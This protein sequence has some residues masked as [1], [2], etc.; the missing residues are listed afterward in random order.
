MLLSK[1]K[2]RIKARKNL[3]KYLLQFFAII[4]FL[5]GS[6][7]AGSILWFE[8]LVFFAEI[9]LD[10]RQ[11]KYFVFDIHNVLIRASFFKRLNLYLVNYAS[12][13]NIPLY[14]VRITLQRVYPIMF[15]DFGRSEELVE[16]GKQ[17]KK[18]TLGEIQYSDFNRFLSGFFKKIKSSVSD[19]DE[20]MLLDEVFMFVSNTDHFA[21]Y[22][23]QMQYGFKIAERIHRKFGPKALYILADT[24]E[25]LLYSYQKMHK[26]LDL[27]FPKEQQMCTG[28][29]GYAKPDL[30]VYKTFLKKMGL[31]ASQTVYIDNV[32]LHV[33]GAERCG[34][35][36]IHCSEKS[37]SLEALR[38]Y[39]S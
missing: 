13:N 24:S 34:M 6:W 16:Y 14:K 19:K 17:L 39:L 21:A 23:M 3:V 20:L 32:R 22:A 15:R 37:T 9:T 33:E 11:P 38:R 28:Q 29:I 26:Q 25:P 36:G 27:L 30:I 2:I 12:V 35:I 10:R 18:I 5:I 4:A 31:P 8:G 7:Y 1:A